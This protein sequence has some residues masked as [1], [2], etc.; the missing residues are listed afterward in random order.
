MWVVNYLQH[1]YYCRVVIN[2]LS[3]NR[4]A[5]PLPI[6]LA[7]RSA[8]TWTGVRAKR[9]EKV[10]SVCTPFSM[11]PMLGKIMRYHHWWWNRHIWYWRGRLTKLHCLHH[12]WQT[13]ANKLNTSEIRNF[14]KFTKSRSSPK[15]AKLCIFGL[16]QTPIPD[17]I[18][19]NTYAL[20]QT[21]E[22]Q[23]LKFVHQ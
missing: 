14:V 4:F 13:V 17:A 1:L 6:K 7:V 21:T 12:V 15:I 11:E 23:D 8:R 10:T 18:L 2:S 16:S 22:F 9:L 3:H 19:R 5:K 20:F